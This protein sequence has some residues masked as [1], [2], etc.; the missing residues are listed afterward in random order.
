[1]SNHWRKHILARI[2]ESPD[3]QERFYVAF[4]TLTDLWTNDSTVSLCSGPEAQRDHPAHQAIVAMG[5]VAIPLI[6]RYWTEHPDSA[7]WQMTLGMI[8]KES[9]VP[10]EHAGM[11]DKTREDWYEWGY[12]KGYITRGPEI[13]R[14]PDGNDP[15]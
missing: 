11:Y 3:L 15:D 1:M 7:W 14:L 12:R 6:F 10:P 13:I 5:E 8:A 9:P 2:K 4:L